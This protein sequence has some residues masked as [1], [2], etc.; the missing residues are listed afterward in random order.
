ME[1]AEK[2][3]GKLLWCALPLLTNVRVGNVV[4]SRKKILCETRLKVVQNRTRPS[5][6]ACKPCFRAV[7]K[8]PQARVLS[9]GKPKGLHDRTPLMNEGS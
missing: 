1:E 7:S 9:E 2:R 5:N 3:Q 4:S 8:P 6:F